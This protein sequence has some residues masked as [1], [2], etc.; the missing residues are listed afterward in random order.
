[1]VGASER[2]DTLAWDAPIE[3]RIVLVMGAEGAGLARL[4]ERSCDVLARLPVRGHV[5]SLNVAAATAVLAYEWVRRQGG[6]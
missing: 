6:A 1:M 5:G 3:G 4:T 2:G